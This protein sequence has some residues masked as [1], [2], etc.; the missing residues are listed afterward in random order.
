MEILIDTVSPENPFI[1]IF[2]ARRVPVAPLVDLAARV[3]RPKQSG[4][5]CYNSLAEQ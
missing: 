2:H 3:R 4:G 1:V 5:L